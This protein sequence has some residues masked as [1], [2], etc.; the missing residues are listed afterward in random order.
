M[1]DIL[2]HM[3]SSDTEAILKI[4]TQSIAGRQATIGARVPAFEKWNYAHIP[5]FYMV[6]KAEDVMFDWDTLPKALQQKVCEGVAEVSSYSSRISQKIGIV[7]ILLKYL[8]PSTK[9]ADFWTLQAQIFPENIPRI[10]LL[11]K[12]G[13]RQKGILEK[14]ALMTICITAGLWWDLFLMER[15]SKRVGD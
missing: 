9:E 4:Y 6:S 12:H 7:S 3:Q 15:R 8:I 2:W 5:E 11:K 10:S 14:I 13:F 1:T